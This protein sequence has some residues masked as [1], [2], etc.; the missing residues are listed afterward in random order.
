VVTGDFGLSIATRRPVLAEVIPAVLN[1]L[2]LAAGSMVLG[3][4]FGVFLGT[5]SAYRNGKA[6]DRA[7]SAIGIAGISI[8]QYWLAM[9]MIVLFAVTFRVLPATGMGEPTATPWERFTHLIL[10]TL[11]L[12]VV[13]AGII[14]KSVRSSVAEILKQDYMQ[15][16]RAKGLTNRRILLHVARNAAPPV[17]AV[18]GLQFA[19]LL[20]G[21]IL[22]E[23]V[24]SWPGT[25]FLLH[26]SIFMRDL[27][28]LQGTILVLA[29]FFVLTN[30]LVDI[31]QMV[32]DPRVRRNRKIGASA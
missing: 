32:F 28:V 30:L 13:P 26:S 22:V 4:F 20:G 3:A 31:L 2:K 18:A 25:G 8:P 24:Y 27:P 23:T 16:L 19:H 1:T 7:I 17:L 14:S 12:C 5:L 21:S 15:A 10:P 6:S 9:V 11:T 29:M